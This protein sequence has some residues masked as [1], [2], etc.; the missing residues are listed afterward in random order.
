MI[1]GCGRDMPAAISF[2][3]LRDGVKMIVGF[4]GGCHWCTEAVFASLRGVS[5]VDQ[6]FIK[7]DPP[8]DG[9]SEAVRLQFDPAIIPLS[10]LIE[11]HLRT[12]ASTSSHKLRGKYRSAIYVLDGETEVEARQTLETLAPDF[13]A[14]LVTH[15]LALEDFRASPERYQNYADKNANGPFCTAYI[16]PKLALLRKEYS[17]YLR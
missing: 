17:A 9:W 11:I 14:P 16:D 12:H 10:A 1:N 13:D 8:H 15:V 6:G 4:G 3:H 7:S 2:R 5:N